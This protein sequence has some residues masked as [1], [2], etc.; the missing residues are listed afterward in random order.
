MS[1]RMTV[2]DFYRNDRRRASE[3]STFG[4]QWTLN[5]D[6]TGLYGVH[7][8]KETKELYLLRGPMTPPFLPDSAGRWNMNAPR[9]ADDQYQVI[10]LG[11]AKRA[12]VVERALKGWRDRMGEPNSLQWVLDRLDIPVNPLT[13]EYS[14]VADQAEPGWRRDQ[15]LLVLAAVVVGAMLLGAFLLGI[16]RGMNVGARAFTASAPWFPAVLINDRVRRSEW[17]RFER[18]AIR[19]VMAVG[20]LAIA[21]AVLSRPATLP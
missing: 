8:L 7:W 5:A 12:S 6:A 3:E 15:F 4:V 18:L 21:A 17:T 2:R 1:M 14:S 16:A 9:F 20:G 11:T 13:V 19:V 10:L